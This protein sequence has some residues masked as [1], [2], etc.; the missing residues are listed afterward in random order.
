[1]KLLFII[2]FS[3]NSLAIDIVHSKKSHSLTYEML[4]DGR[5]YNSHVYSDYDL[6]FQLHFNYVED[7]LV[8]K[9]QSNLK[10]VDTIVDSLSSVHLGAAAYLTKNILVGLQT[11]YGLVDYEYYTP[12]S[13]IN[14]T[15]I[16][17][18]TSGFSDL[19]LDVKWRFL[20]KERYSMALMPF[21]RIPTGGGEIPIRIFSPGTSN[22][23]DINHKVLSEDSWGLGG[24]LIYE[25]YFDFMNVVV[26]LGYLQADKAALGELDLRKKL[27]L[28]IGAYVPL[29]SK[30]GVNLEWLRY[31]SLPFN[32]NQNPNELFAGLSA[33]I[34]KNVVVFA[35][36]AFGNVLS[37][38]DGN[39]FRISA[40]VKF[41]PR[42][43]GD[44]K[45]PIELLNNDPVIKNEIVQIQECKEPYIFEKSN[46][47][48]VRFPHNVSTIYDSR[49]LN[50]VIRR[51]K[52]RAVDI[53]NVQIVGHTSQKG[54]EEYNQRLSEKRAQSVTNVLVEH[55]INKDIISSSG[56]GERDLLDHESSSI[57]DEVNRRVEFVV[58]LKQIDG[59]YCKE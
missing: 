58:T 3:I 9:T 26:N 43:W 15:K 45:K 44:E 40:G 17:D 28:G 42:I 13:P 22:F 11:Y 51:I 55:G 46:K 25:K 31:F 2:L 18:S 14:S 19:I 59:Y 1:M 49:E 20:S 52:K 12:G 23:Q 16:S 39:D 35:G 10:Q 32:S 34:T 38:D 36:A 33:G 47:V 21:L 30:V 5:L 50:D 53:M 27:S 8:R 57:A 54:S 37:D 56:R 24:R 29:S 6:L 4:E 48:I 7:P 41:S